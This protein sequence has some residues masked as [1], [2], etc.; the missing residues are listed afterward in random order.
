MIGPH[1][2]FWVVVDRVVSDRNR[3]VQGLWH[4]HPN[5]RVSVTSDLQPVAHVVDN[6]THIGIDVVP[7]TGGTQWVKTVIINGQTTPVLQGWYSP[8]YGSYSPSPTVSYTGNAPAGRSTFAWLLV[9]TS[10]GT[11]SEATG[12]I[13]SVN[14]THVVLEVLL[15][16]K[17]VTLIADVSM[18]EV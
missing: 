9:P 16:G 12:K 5:C 8:N 18:E 1:S 2:R 13:T 7:M 11:A 14:D 4:A 17:S 10:Q 6:E 15:R 3:S